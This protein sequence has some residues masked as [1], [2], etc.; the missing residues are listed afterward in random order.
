MNLHEFVKAWSFSNKTW[1]YAY[2]K[3]EPTNLLSFFFVTFNSSWQLVSL[4]LII[5][6]CAKSSK[7]Y[8]SASMQEFFYHFQ[9]S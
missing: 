6:A 4:I 3:Y 2:L 8:V 5:I 1:L 7:Q 9:K